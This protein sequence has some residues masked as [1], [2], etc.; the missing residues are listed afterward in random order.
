MKID[1]KVS[2]VSIG[3]SYIYTSTGADVW[4][5]SNDKFCLHSKPRQTWILAIKQIF[6]LRKELENSGL[7]ELMAFYWNETSDTSKNKKIFIDQKDY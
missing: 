6:I 4:T 1:W 2:R 7:M 5:P 3:S